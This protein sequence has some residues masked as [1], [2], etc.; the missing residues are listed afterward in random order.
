[1]RDAGLTWREIAR[2]VGLSAARCMQLAKGVQGGGERQ[3][4]AITH[5]AAPGATC[6]DGAP[7]NANTKDGL[8]RIRRH[9]CEVKVRGE[10]VPDD[11]KIHDHLSLSRFAKLIRKE[12]GEAKAD[13][14]EVPAYVAKYVTGT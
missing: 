14:S 5:P 3:E 6:A 1:M 4:A 12:M 2:D 7:F 13:P 9:L 10:R 8:L 11:L